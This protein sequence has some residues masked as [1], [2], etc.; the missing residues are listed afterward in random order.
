[1][2]INT[3][4]H[5]KTIVFNKGGNTISERMMVSQARENNPQQILIFPTM[6]IKGPQKM[7]LYGPLNML[8][9]GISS[10]SKVLLA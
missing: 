7:A 5:T 1:M 3:S 4:N 2:L 6:A 8:L 10:I 9:Y